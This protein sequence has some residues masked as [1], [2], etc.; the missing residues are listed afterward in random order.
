MSK[1]I[2]LRENAIAAW[3][4]VNDFYEAHGGDLLASEQREFVRLT[5]QATAAERE[6]RASGGEDPGVRTQ[7]AQSAAGIV[8]GARELL[9]QYVSPGPEGFRLPFPFAGGRSGIAPGARRSVHSASWGAA[10][11][12]ESNHSR[13]GA[14]LLAPSGSVPVTVPL[15]TEAIIEGRAVRF[16]RQ[17]IPAEPAPGGAFA[18]MRQTVRTNN[19][20][21]V[22]K[23]GRKP[24]SIYTLE[25]IDGTTRVVAHLSEPIP[26][27]DIADAALLSAF[28]DGELRYGLD[29]GLD[30][31][32]IS[33]AGGDSH[34]TGILASGLQTQDP[35]IDI[36]TTARMA[37]T[38]LQVVDLEP[39]G[40]VLNPLDWEAIELAATAAY[41]SNSNQPA[42]TDS[43]ARR[44]WGVP[45][46]VTN[47]MPA[48]TG[49]LGDFAG[50]AV[51][52]MTEE[53]TV[54]WSENTWDPDALGEGDGAS[55]FERNL[56]R[57]RAE[58]R[59]NIG[60]TRPFGFVAVDL[61]TGS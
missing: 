21:V 48:G 4:A 36:L 19:A 47:S 58:M 6:F 23:G 56:I 15:R 22:V 61:S 26:R 54:D 11:L 59:A 49:L 18:F 39:S 57:F 60:V 9:A 16:L 8:N 32:I 12:A 51:L 45:V 55:D 42:A 29:L 50:S 13:Y 3:Q 37:V 2:T 20:A 31:E 33:G 27:S 14:A 10:V 38:K 43:M 35:D 1:L 34:M 24:T 7:V 41:A 5:E 46:V 40:W 44:L 53:G 28:V 52:Y 25:R 30:A 17:L